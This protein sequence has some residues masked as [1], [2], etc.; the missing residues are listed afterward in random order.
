M[1]VY[2]TNGEGKTLEA[3]KKSGFR[4]SIPP[5]AGLGFAGGF[6]NGGF[7]TGIGAGFVPNGGMNFGT[8]LGFGT[9]LPNNN[10]MGSSFGPVGLGNNFVGT[11]YTGA[12]FGSAGLG[13][14]ILGTGFAGTSFGVDAMSNPFGYSNSMVYS[15]YGNNMGGFGVNTRVFNQPGLGTSYWPNQQG[16]MT[17]GFNGVGSFNDPSGFNSLGINGNSFSGVNSF[18]NGATGLNGLNGIG[19]GGL[20]GLNGIGSGV[21]FNNNFG[22]LSNGINGFSSANSLNNRFGT[23][24][25]NGLNNFSSFNTGVSSSGFGNPSLFA[26]NS[27]GNYSF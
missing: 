12:S 4:R 2:A 6:G 21:G 14:N 17:N 10:F 3:E 11:G 18:R 9:G 16:L 24:F 13:N 23:G 26:T 22:S 27:F 25:N 1:L 19:T 7:N 15:P 5:G 8:G 20:N